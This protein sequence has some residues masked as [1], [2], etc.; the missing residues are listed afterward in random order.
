LLKGKI[1]QKLFKPKTC[2]Q[3]GLLTNAA[4]TVFKFFA[5]I[6]GLSKAMIADALHSFSDILTTAIVYVGICIGERP[7]DEDHPYGHGNAETIAAS[8][9]ALVIVIIGVGAGISSIRAVI[10]QQFELPL[11]IAL[12]AAAVS[13]VV[14]EGLFRYTIKVGNLSNNP[15]VV[16]DA[17]HHRSDAYSS[18]AALVGIAGARI[19]SVYLDPLAGLVVSGFI[20]KIAFKLIRSNIGIIMDEKP[21]PAFINKI[22]SIVRQAQGVKKADS[23]KVHR[24]GSTFTI[25]IEIAVDSA[26]SVEE[27]HRIASTV[28]DS[29]VAKMKNV[30]DVMVHVNPAK[31]DKR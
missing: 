2:I 10:N 13:I 18:I 26:L 22:G 17:W 7:A 14:K 16:A 28:K 25:D 29:L 9:V 31:E 5:G 24:R 6:L 4:L 11:N 20:I 30:R 15:A 8:M 3:V 21:H 19:F 12:W 23:I 27:G 1:Y